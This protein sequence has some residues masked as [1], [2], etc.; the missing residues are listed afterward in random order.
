[1]NGTK[2][3]KR[4]DE[5]CLAATTIIAILLALLAPH[6]THAQSLPPDPRFGAVEAF[7]DPQAAQDLNLGWERIIFDWSQLQ[8]SGPNDWNQFQVQDSWID[9]AAQHGRQVVGLMENTPHWA[10]DGTTGSGVPRGLYLP[11][12]DPNNL[13]AGFVRAL[14]KRTVGR[15]DHWIIW[16]EPDIEPPD[17]GIQFDGSVADYYQL[18]KVAY[19]VAKQENPNAIIHLAGLTYYHDTVYHRVAYLQRFITEAKKD[20]TAAANHD[21]FDVASLHIYHN[22]DEVYNVASIMRNILRQNGLKQPLWI[23]ETNVQPSSDP[24]WPWPNPTWVVSLDQQADFLIH[25]FAMGLAAGADRIAVYKLIDMPQPQ[26]GW[27]PDGLLR[28][29]RSHRPA[30][31]ALK[32][33]TTYFRDTRSARL[34]RTGSTDIVTLDRGSKTT[35]I[36]WARSAAT[37]T[38]SLPAFTQQATLVLSNGSTQPLAAINNQYRLTL[39]GAKCDDPHFGCAVGGSPIILVEDAPSKSGGSVIVSTVTPAA[40]CLNCAPASSPTPA[41][42]STPCPDCTPTLTRTITP[43]ATSILEPTSTSTSTPTAT[44]TAT[45]TASPTYTFT[46]TPT[47]LPSPTSTPIVVSTE[48]DPP[49]GLFAIGAALILILIVVLRKR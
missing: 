5:A 7:Y 32:V 20:S 29:D 26:P 8:G 35:R 9:D 18:V 48:N 13:W 37:T 1:M 39:P 44:S 23:N 2:K 46:P 4:K 43:T 28:T 38:I 10:T 12:D 22:S 16:N 21:Y 11:I 40:P 3:S 25:S 41:P 31:A 6:L 27:P 42:T 19:Q 47:V 17:S 15:V 34:V 30:Y 24:L 14:V 36:A 49:I 45:P 33:I